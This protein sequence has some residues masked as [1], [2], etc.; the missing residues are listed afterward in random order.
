[1]RCTRAPSVMRFFRSQRPS[2]RC[3]QQ[4]ARQPT[5]CSKHCVPAVGTNS[6]HD[7]STKS[8]ISRWQSLWLI[9]TFFLGI[10]LLLF[11]ALSVKWNEWVGKV[12]L[13]TALICCAASSSSYVNESSVFVCFQHTTHVYLFQQLWLWHLSDGCERS[14]CF[15]HRC[16]LLMSYSASQIHTQTLWILDGEP[17]DLF[18]KVAAV[19]LS[20]I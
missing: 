7:A 16:W 14:G 11:F 20:L 8:Y 9:H 4:T 6:A 12:E 18:A 19:N 10:A 2:A 1:M 3:Q 5:V 13:V 17:L 15:P